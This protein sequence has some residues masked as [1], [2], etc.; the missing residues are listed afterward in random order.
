MQFISVDFLIFFPVMVFFIMYFLT[1]GRKYGYWRQII[2]FI[3][4]Q[5]GW[6]PCY[7]CM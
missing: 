7:Y 1:D 6:G 3:S 5:G 2:V 4:G